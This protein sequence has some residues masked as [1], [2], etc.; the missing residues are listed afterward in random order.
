MNVE[1]RITSI[2]RVK[3]QPNKK[4][5]LSRWLSRIS[6]QL[7]YCYETLKLYII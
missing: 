3:T 5:A 7:G 1:E 4:P 6:H 2:F